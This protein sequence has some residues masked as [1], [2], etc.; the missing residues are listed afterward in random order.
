MITLGLIESKKKLQDNH[1]C[2]YHHSNCADQSLQNQQKLRG[3]KEQSVPCSMRKKEKKTISSILTFFYST[4]QSIYE[5]PSQT[6]K[7]F[8]KK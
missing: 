8:N 4:N 1:K 6:L 2:C 5:N 7:K 3:G